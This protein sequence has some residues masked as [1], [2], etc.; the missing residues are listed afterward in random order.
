MPYVIA[1]AAPPG[2]G[3]STLSKALAAKLY[4]ATIVDYDSFQQVTNVNFADVMHWFQ[5]GCDYDDLDIPGLSVAL[6]DLKNGKSIQDPLTGER[7]PATEHIVFE[8]PLGRLHRE[9]GQFIDYLIWIDVPLD[10]ALARNLKA[11][12]AHLPQDNC[13]PAFVWLDDYLGNYIAGVH[14]MLQT[15]RYRITPSA[16][17]IVNGLNAIDAM[18]EEIFADI[19]I[20]LT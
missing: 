10:I 5:Q 3:K 12:L 6:S 2:G 13:A 7:L 18:V 4:G 11:M 9:I 15:Q 20:K 8:T 16:D 19:T 1:I 14:H 17:I